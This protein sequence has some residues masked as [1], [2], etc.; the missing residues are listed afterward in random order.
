VV[1]HHAQT[2]IFACA[3]VSQEFEENYTWV[4][5][6]FIDCMKGVH[7]GGILTY[8]CQSI[9]KHMK[10]VLVG[11]V[12]RYCA[13]HI[14]HKLPMKWGRKPNNDGLTEQLKY[15]VYGPIT[16]E[17]FEDKWCQL[18]KKLGYEHDS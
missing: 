2:I 11:T 9:K 18:L 8:Q 4:F 5:S 7:R 3:L 16:K 1:N 17:E 13:W 12:H 6:I 15:V 14:L 10:N